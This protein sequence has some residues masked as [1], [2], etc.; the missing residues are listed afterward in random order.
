[1]KQ[2]Q[3]EIILQQLPKPTNP[4]PH[5][6]QYTTPATIAADMIYT[7]YSFGDIQD[8]VVVDLGCGTGILATGAYLMGAKKVQG[9]D[10]DQ[11][12]I[13][14]AQEEAALHKRSIEFYTQE[15]TSV[16]TTCDT[17]LMNPPF[18]AQKANLKAD[19]KFIEK[20][21]EIA[22]VLYSFHL[23]KTVPFMEKMVTALH[24]EITLQKDYDFPIKWI[25]DF[26][27]KQVV[28][29]KVSLLRILTHK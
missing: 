4:V 8:K 14:I 28:N 5:L 19:R 23:K 15:I 6:E 29:Y 12:V 17:V 27:Y 25:F 2:R 18:G 10:I 1:M 3:L 13:A 20:G 9:Y 26:H 11:N 7:A 24:G 22:S 16:Q 21:F